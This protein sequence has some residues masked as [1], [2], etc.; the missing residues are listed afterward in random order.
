MIRAFSSVALL[1][2]TPALAQ[3]SAPDPVWPT[4]AIPAPRDIPYPGTL[5]LDVDATDNQRGIFKVKQSIPVAKAGHMILLYPKWIPGKHGPRGEIEK[6]AGLEFR[7]NGKLLPWRRDPLDMFAFHIDVPAGAKKV[8]ASF[9]F[10]SATVSD[11]GRIVATPNLESVQFFSLSLY[12]AG[13]FVRR[14]PIQATVKYPDGW[15]AA[16]AVPS[17]ATGSTYSYEKTSYEI[18]VDS[19][20]LAGRYHRAFPLSERVTLETFADTPEELE[21]KP[22]QIEAHKRM[23]EQAVRLFGVQ[24]YDNYR[25]LFSISDDLGGIGVEHHR[26][27]EIGRTPGYFTKWDDNF[28]NR[29][30]F[31][32]EFVHS[33]DGKYRRGADLW[34]PDYRTP[35]RG[36]LLWVYEGQTQFWGYVLQARSGLVSKDDTLEALAGIAANLD[37]RQGRV[38]RSVADTTN[39]PVITARGAKGWMSYQR[40]EDYYNEGLMI[41]LEADSVIRAKSGG[42][43]SIDDFARAFFGGRDGDYGQV[44]YTFD[45]VVNTL[46]GIVA[47]DWR[48]FLDK[49]VNGVAQPT[50]LKGI[51]DGGYKLV[52]TDTPNR[53]TAK[54]SVDLAYSLGLTIGSGGIS[55]VI[56]G[57]PA[58]DAGITLADEIIAVNG[59]GYSGD[60]IKAAVQAAKGSKEPVRLLLKRGERYRE[61]AIDYHGGLRYPHLQKAGE[62]ESGL[63][64]LLQSR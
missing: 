6:V 15:T 21:A 28:T 54:N 42:T 62:G 18:L 61:V 13:Y 59:R 24:H 17:K 8:D 36:S 30:V 52:Y 25:F 51:T 35:M 7:A 39:D 46:N 14:I 4:D 41:W 10:I 5:T 23:V 34:T 37:S 11:Q 2:A 57:G 43:R 56:W 31:P 27:T 3:N 9:Q 1:L 60:R 38:W 40:S 53:A 63:D 29:N 32:H 26:S 64:K 22:E 47:Y 58:F 19:P 49:R 20:A 12:P 16:S 48:S 33:W 50:L 55:G 44:T 45:D